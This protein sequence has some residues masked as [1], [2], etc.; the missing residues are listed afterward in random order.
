MNC[1]FWQVGGVVSVLS[2]AQ[3]LKISIARAVLKNPCIL[4]LDEVTEALDAEAESSVQDALDL[5][6]LGRTT[7]VI[8]Q[9]LSVVRTADLIAVL[10]EGQLVELGTHDNLLHANGLYR[11]LVKHEEAVKPAKR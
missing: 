3:K 8:A 5:L 1:A 2:E 11:D 10:E 9:R 4:L 7:I 6:T